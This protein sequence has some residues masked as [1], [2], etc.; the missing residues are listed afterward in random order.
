MPVRAFYSPLDIRPV[1]SR[2]RWFVTA[3]LALFLPRVLMAAEASSALE[4]DGDR[5]MSGGRVANEQTQNDARLETPLTG[6]VAV[7]TGA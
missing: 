7:G 2:Y 1:V 5:D 6:G 3:M 4:A